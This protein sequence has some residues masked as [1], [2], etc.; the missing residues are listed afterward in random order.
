MWALVL[1]FCPLIGYLTSVKPCVL[2]GSPFGPF[3]IRQLDHVIT[4]LTCRFPG[5]SGNAGVPES[6][7]VTHTE[8]VLW[9]LMSV[10]P[11]E[12][13]ARVPRTGT[14][15]GTSEPGGGLPGSGGGRREKRHPGLNFCPTQSC[16]LC[17]LRLNLWALVW[18]WALTPTPI[19]S[20][21]PLPWSPA[22]R[23]PYFQLPRPGGHRRAGTTSIQ[24]DQ[25]LGQTP[26]RA[27]LPG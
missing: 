4:Q 17:L 21:W 27:H 8:A 3:Q 15:N 1:S 16:A 25:S 6:P 14:S 7:W 9:P 12:G 24:S 19:P 5:G 10:L 26:S 18:G 11:L 13:E 20:L 2:R 23:H 22:P